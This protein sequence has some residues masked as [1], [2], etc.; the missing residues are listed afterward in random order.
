MA[1]VSNP[2]KESA[3]AQSKK[4]METIQKTIFQINFI[5]HTTDFP[6]TN[7]NYILI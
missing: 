7:Y 6:K 2:V 5:R 1:P 3:S 4:K